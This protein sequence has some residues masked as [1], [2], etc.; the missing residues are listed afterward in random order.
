MPAAAIALDVRCG[1]D[2]LL[3]GYRLDKQTTLA[4]QPLAVTLYWKAT[5]QPDANLDLSLNGYA[6]QLENVAKLD[7]WPGGGLLPTNYWEP[8]MLYPDRYLLSTKPN[9]DT[10]AL[11]KLGIDWN[12]DLLHPS[13]NQRVLCSVGG[14]PV[15]SLILD[16][17]GLVGEQPAGSP[18]SSAPIAT[19]Q[20]DIQLLQARTAYEDGQLDDG[21]DLAG[22]QSRARRLHRYSLIFLTAAASRWLKPTRRRVKDTGPLHAG[23]RRSR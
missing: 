19:L 21:P 1:D 7:T 6:Y 8:G 16:A 17:G 3:A 2:I 15:D 4:G 9:S 5:G 22:H 18:A 23:V 14:R 10:P 11:V 20:H 13:Q 12:T